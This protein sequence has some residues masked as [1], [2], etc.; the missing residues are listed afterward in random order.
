MMSEVKRRIGEAVHDK[1]EEA[2]AV[3]S[4]IQQDIFTEM[5]VDPH[6]GLSCLPKLNLQ[7]HNDLDFM[8]RFYAFVAK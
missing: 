4:A 7:F 3:T 5:G 8:I 1:Q 6:F 2:V